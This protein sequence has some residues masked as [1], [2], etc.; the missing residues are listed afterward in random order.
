V[1]V[2]ILKSQIQDE[3]AFRDALEKLRQA[4]ID[5]MMGE[6]IGTSSPSDPC[7]D[8]FIKRTPT[9]PDTPDDI[10]IDYEIVNDDPPPPSEEELKA[11]ALTELRAQEQAEIAAL[12]PANKTRLMQ[13]EV[14]RAFRVPEDERSPAQ[15]KIITDWQ[16]LQKQI[17][18]IQYAYA[19]REAEL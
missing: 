16:D 13:M 5:H 12:T 6:E 9:G 10:S 14:S 11:R 19:K 2:Q 8:Q 3:A 7:L 17:E 1:T 4:K 18:E 15:A